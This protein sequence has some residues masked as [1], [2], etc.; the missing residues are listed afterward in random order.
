M[1]LVVGL[2]NPGREY[3]DT[4][5]NVGFRVVDKLADRF[6]TSVDDKKFAPESGEA[7]SAATLLCS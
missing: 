6:G 5:H 1:R 2:G 7:G 3:D 4:R